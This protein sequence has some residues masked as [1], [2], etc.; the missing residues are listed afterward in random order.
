M[1]HWPAE[2]IKSKRVPTVAVPV[3]SYHFFTIITSGFACAAKPDCICLQCCP[4]TPEGNSTRA[5][6]VRYATE[7][8]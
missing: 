4:D 1:S 7:V 3:K 5:A 6:R 8:P 2:I